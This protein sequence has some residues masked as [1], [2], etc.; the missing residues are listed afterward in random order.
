MNIFDIKNGIFMFNEIAFNIIIDKKDNIWFNANNLCRILKYKD[1]KDALRKHV[2]K[3]DKTYLENI[4]QMY[5]TEKGKNVQMNTIYI[6]ESGL[7]SLLFKSRL[8]IGIKFKKWITSE[9]IPN[10]RKHGKYIINDK[11]K[12]KIKKLNIELER[13]KKENIKINNINE[14][15]E[16]NIKKE[17][18]PNGGVFYITKT[19]KDKIYKIGITKELNKRCKTYNTSC[20]NNVNVIY[21]KRV[22]CPKQV[23][24]CVKSLLYKYRYNNK[25]EFYNCDVK[26]I[27]NALRN[28]LLVI[29]NNNNCK[30][31][32]GGNI[33][34]LL[35]NTYD[36]LNNKKNKYIEIL[37]WCLM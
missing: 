19:N 33:N 4:K 31:Q 9:V 23:E 10:I 11:Y 3:Q 27:K 14:E 28:C 20:V 36:I 26:I 18:Y 16:N 37:K 8:E 24:L 32:I 22:E 29:K 12:K 2:D 17:I 35:N 25:R 21:Y 15:L 1:P 7:Y 5:K 30:N 34:S 13:I 6:N